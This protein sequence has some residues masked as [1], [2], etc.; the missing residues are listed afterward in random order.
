MYDGSYKLYL[1]LHPFTEILDFFVPPAF[2]VQFFKPVPN[3]F[4]SITFGKSF[5]LRQIKHLFADLHLLI[6][7]TF[8][9]Q[10]ANALDISTLNTL[11]VTVDFPSVGGSNLIDN[12]DNGGFSSAIRTQKTKDTAFRHAQ[13]YIIQSAVVTI[14]FNDMTDI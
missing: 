10:L 14:L 12:T 5:E 4:C 7:P 3:A 13:R 6:S 2:D 8:F 11:A 9:W 1:L